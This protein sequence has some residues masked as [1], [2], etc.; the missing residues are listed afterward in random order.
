MK[1]QYKSVYQVSV[2]LVVLLN[3]VGESRKKPEL[4]NH[5]DKRK[6]MRTRWGSNRA[7]GQLKRLMR[8]LEL[9]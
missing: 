4:D 5:S 9:E 6:A 8:S 7:E 2:V 3:V 1:L